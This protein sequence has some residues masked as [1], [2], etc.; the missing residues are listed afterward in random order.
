MS[1][2]PY[3]CS[4]SVFVSLV[5]LF[6]NEKT[7][8]RT[9]SSKKKHTF[10][11]E[12][13]EKWSCVCMWVW[14]RGNHLSW[15]WPFLGTQIQISKNFESDSRKKNTHFQHFAPHRFRLIAFDAVVHFSWD[16]L[17]PGISEEA[18]SSC[19]FSVHRKSTE[20]RRTLCSSLTFLWLYFPFLW[21]VRP[22]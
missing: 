10:L 12:S 6:R 9:Y 8:P 5:L 22:N 14:I 4:S 19:I 13:L 7:Q 11:R 20:K 15:K 2:L 3:A 21:V 17:F 16:H 1:K 18:R